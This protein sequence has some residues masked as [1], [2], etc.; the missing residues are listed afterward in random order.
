MAALPST[1]TRHTHTHTQKY[2]DTDAPRACIIHTHVVVATREEVVSDG[3]RGTEGHRKR[4]PGRL[5][6]VQTGGGLERP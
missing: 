1:A 2:L 5:V 3:A 4:K 6:V